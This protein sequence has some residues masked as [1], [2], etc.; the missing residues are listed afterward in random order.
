[1]VTNT[2]PTRQRVDCFIIPLQ[3]VFETLKYHVYMIQLGLEIDWREYVIYVI[4]YIF[5]ENP[6]FQ[7]ALQTTE[8]RTMLM[9]HGFSEEQMAWIEHYV[10]SMAISLVGDAHAYIKMLSK[11]DQ[12]NGFNWDINH[13]RDLL[14]QLSYK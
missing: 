8:C 5:D 7:P 2:H 3:A 14:I 1:M 4:K 6:E 11:E 9:R 13:S 10:I 12:I